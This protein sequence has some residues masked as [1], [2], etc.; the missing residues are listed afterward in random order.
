VPRTADLKRN[1]D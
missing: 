1:G